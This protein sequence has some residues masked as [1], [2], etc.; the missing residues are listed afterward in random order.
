MGTRICYYSLWSYSAPVHI[1][2]WLQ[3]QEGQP[4]RQT[5]LSSNHL[6]LH[7]S[8]QTCS[9]EPAGR[10]WSQSTPLK[11]RVSVGTNLLVTHSFSH[12]NWWLKSSPTSFA[13]QA[14]SSGGWRKENVIP[15]ASVWLLSRQSPQAS[16]PPCSNDCDKTN[17][18]GRSWGRCP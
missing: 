6:W 10:E 5:E 1:C 8:V 16:S 15:P 3:D 18:H 4:G 14:S 2:L 17:K 9:A 11:M 12:I 7:I 13:T